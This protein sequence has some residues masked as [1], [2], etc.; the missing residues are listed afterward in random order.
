MIT[1][2]DRARIHEECDQQ[3]WAEAERVMIVQRQHKQWRESLMSLPFEEK[4]DMARS[5]ED[6]GLTKD[7]WIY[8]EATNHILDEDGA[9][10][11]RAEIE[12]W[13]HDRNIWCQMET[14]YFAEGKFE[15]PEWCSADVNFRWK[16][17]A[18]VWA[19]AFDTEK[20]ALEFKLRWS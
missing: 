1:E 13:C 20:A 15:R 14:V 10:A 5:L 18:D 4:L 3:Q 11:L 12:Q 16:P 8:V 6:W 17:L 9:F 19:V 2:H 7:D